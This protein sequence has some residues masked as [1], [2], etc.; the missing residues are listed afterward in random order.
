MKQNAALKETN[1]ADPSQNI[2][3]LSPIELD[4]G[5]KINTPTV[6]NAK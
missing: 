4:S 2:M 5:Q 1:D 6:S 3:S